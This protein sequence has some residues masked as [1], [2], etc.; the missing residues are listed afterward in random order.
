MVQPVELSWVMKL[1]CKRLKESEK[2]YAFR[3]TIA[4]LYLQVRA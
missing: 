1:A 2:Q 4:S 3:I